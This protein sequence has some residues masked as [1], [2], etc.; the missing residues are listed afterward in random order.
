MVSNHVIS[1][2]DFFVRRRL[3]FVE[4]CPIGWLDVIVAML[5]HR[6][7][8]KNVFWEFDYC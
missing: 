3:D 7:K 5:V 6:T 4:L 1:K 8:E 2:I